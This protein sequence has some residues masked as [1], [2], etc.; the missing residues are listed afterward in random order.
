MEANYIIGAGTIKG[1]AGGPLSL[2]DLGERTT[3]RASHIEYSDPI[4]KWVVTDAKSNQPLFEHEDY[5]VCLAWET[6]HYNQ[7]L[8]GSD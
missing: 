7:Q 4:S 3:E 1:L 6:S 2:A 5:N 8:A